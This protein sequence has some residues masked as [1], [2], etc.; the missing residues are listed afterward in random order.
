MLSKSFKLV[1]L[2][3]F[4]C[5]CDCLYFMLSNVKNGTEYSTS[6]I[7]DYCLAVRWMCLQEV[8]LSIVLWD[9]VQ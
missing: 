8:K 6:V 2:L 4:I 5:D 1:S 7:P 9:P 3:F